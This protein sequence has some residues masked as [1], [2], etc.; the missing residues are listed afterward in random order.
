MRLQVLRYRLHEFLRMATQ[1]SA[2]RA[3][4]A[5]L[6]RQCS[7]KSLYFARPQRQTMICLSAGVRWRA[8]GDIEPQHLFLQLRIAPRSKHPS[9]AM[10]SRITPGKKI[11]IQR[12]E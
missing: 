11:A 2:T 12:Q 4:N 3:A 7:R 10:E 8:L 9:V 1:L 5:Q 6:R